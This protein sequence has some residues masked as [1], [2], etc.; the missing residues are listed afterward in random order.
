M[1][2]KEIFLKKVAFL[3]TQTHHPKTT[4]PPQNHHNFTTKNHH[5]SA[6]IR[7]T[8]PEKRL[9]T[10]RRKN[11][12]KQTQLPRHLDPQMLISQPGTHQVRLAL[13]S[14][15]RRFRQL[16]PNLPRT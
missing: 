7:K 12:L 6:I 8:P 9:S 2:S 13:V 15:K 11:P 5:E 4:I 10:M 3:S 16:Q 14:A 1:K